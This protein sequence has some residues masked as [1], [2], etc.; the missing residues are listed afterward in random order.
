[1]SLAEK[2][3]LQI[4]TKIKPQIYLPIFVLGKLKFSLASKRLYHFLDG[5][6]LKKLILTLGLETVKGHFGL[7][8]KLLPPHLSTT[9]ID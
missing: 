2:Y 7:W 9:M 8:V 6:V 3:V 1:M 4:F 5:K